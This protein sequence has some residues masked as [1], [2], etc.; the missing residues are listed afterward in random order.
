MFCCSFSY[1]EGET[2]QNSSFGRKKL[3]V[4]GVL[5]EPDINTVVVRFVTLCFPVYCHCC[6]FPS[7]LFSPF[8][9]GGGGVGMGSGGGGGQLNVCGWIMNIKNR[10]S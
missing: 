6:P 8:L 1:D 5:N 9:G 2:W 7:F 4:N 3:T 10:C